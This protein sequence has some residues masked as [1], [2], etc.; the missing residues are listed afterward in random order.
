MNLV[1]MIENLREAEKRNERK[2][3]KEKRRDTEIETAREIVVMGRR[4]GI[5]T[6]EIIDIETER[7]GK[8]IGIGIEI[9]M[10]VILTEVVTVTG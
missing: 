6:A 3:G 4:K 8:G 5:T 2:I 10:M 1:I 9:G 7:I